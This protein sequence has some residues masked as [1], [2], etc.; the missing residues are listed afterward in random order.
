MAPKWDTVAFRKASLQAMLA[1]PLSNPFLIA[2]LPHLPL[3][4]VKAFP[5]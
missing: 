2:E 1:M 3:A 5:E 4:H